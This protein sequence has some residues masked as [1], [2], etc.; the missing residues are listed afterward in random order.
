[1]KMDIHIRITCAKCMSSKLQLFIKI[2]SNLQRKFCIGGVQWQ[3]PISRPSTVCSGARSTYPAWPV[4]TIC[5]HVSVWPP[6]SSRSGRPRCSTYSRGRSPLYPKTAGVPTQ[7]KDF[8]SLA[9]L[10]LDLI[11]WMAVLC[12]VGFRLMVGRNPWTWPWKGF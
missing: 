8:K 11:N 7:V 3:D 10:Q 12:V 2:Y 6:D 9:Q 4:H 5:S 1:M